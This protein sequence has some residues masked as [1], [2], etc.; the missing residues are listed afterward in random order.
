MK[1]KYD[2][3]VKKG[4]TPG[5]WLFTVKGE[6]RYYIAKGSSTGSWAILNFH[7]STK[8][9]GNTSTLRDA[10]IFCLARENLL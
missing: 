7:A 1:I 10:I 8:V 6:V 5:T 3:R 4:S 2:Y 9:V